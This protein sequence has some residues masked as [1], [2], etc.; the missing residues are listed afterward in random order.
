MTG[1]SK[2]PVAL[3]R[4]YICNDELDVRRE[5]GYNLHNEEAGIVLEDA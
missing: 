5:A 2:E 4:N 3:N 1:I